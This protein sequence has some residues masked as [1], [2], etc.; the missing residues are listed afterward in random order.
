VNDIKDTM[1]SVSELNRISN[2]VVG[3]A[4]EVHRVLGPGLLESV[5]E[6]CLAWELEQHKLMVQRQVELPLRYK[7]TS[8]QSVYR[9][10]LLIQRELIVE[11]KA[12]DALQPV[13]TAQLL[14]YLKL[15][16]ARLGLLLNFNVDVMR[17]GIKRVVNDL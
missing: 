15:K 3:A 17:K 2:R 8:I 9:L 16:S 6:Q 1:L 12:V 13:H 5:Y 7:D 11:V 10:D 4:I 14:S